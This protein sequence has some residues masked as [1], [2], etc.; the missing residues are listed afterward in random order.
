MRTSQ[1]ERRRLLRTYNYLYNKVDEKFDHTKCIYCNE[2]MGVWDHCP[3][4]SSVESMNIEEYKSKGGKFRLY[5]SCWNCNTYL[6]RYPDVDIYS[7]IDYL[8]IKYTKRLSYSPSWTSRELNSLGYSLKQYV[9]NKQVIRNLINKKL[10]Q[11]IQNSLSL[12]FMELV[13]FGENKVIKKLEEKPKIISKTKSNYN[14]NIREVPVLIK[15]DRAYLRTHLTE[16]LNRIRQD[17]TDSKSNNTTGREVKEIPK[18]DIFLH[19]NLN[20]AVVNNRK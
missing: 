2:P 15:H 10:Q 16:I 11:L 13:D 3:P 1:Q 20:N 5:P 4:I 7:R 12:S 9:I 18:A 19:L 14:K 8:V 6:N 17:I